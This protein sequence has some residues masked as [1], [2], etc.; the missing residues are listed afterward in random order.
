[1]STIKQLLKAEKSKGI[2]IHFELRLDK[3][4]RAGR[5]PI[6][7]VYRIEGVRKVYRTSLIILPQ[8]WD[9]K[10]QQAVYIDR[11]TAKKFYPAID[12]DYFLTE[13][14]VTDFNNQLIET[15][16]EIKTA[17]NKFINNGVAYDA[18]M[19][20]EQIKKTKAPNTK[21]AEPTNF[22]F[23]FIDQYIIDHKATREAT[24]LAVYRAMKNYLQAY[25]QHTGNRITFAKIDYSFLQSFQ[26]FLLTCTRVVGGKVV[27]R[28]NNTT[29]AKQL[30]TVKTFIS[31]AKKQGIV[32][33]DSY[34]NFQI[35]RDELEVIALTN[36]EFEA[37]YYF[38]LTNNKRLEQVRDIFCFSCST[39][40]RISDLKQLKREHIKQDEII[41][42]IMKGGR[43]LTVPLN[44]FSRAILAKYETA[45][46]PL[47]MISGQRINDYVKE[48]CELVGINEQV[49]IVRFRGIV[50]EAITYP[51]YELICAHT[52]RK[53]FVCLSLEKGMSAEQVMACTGHSTYASFKRYVNVTNKLKIVSMNKAWGEPMAQNSMRAV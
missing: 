51:K 31:Y 53:T 10:S 3:A 37:L 8:C 30:S 6:R 14:E 22:L 1:M 13:V 48:L 20:I 27:P 50:R 26:N 15:I 11:K 44:P 35:K 33:S 39:G 25:Q 7:V 34:K 52:G 2:T 36:N 32:V 28:L 40:F 9:G 29:I 18:D 16:G 17:A 42:T 21:K 5:A 41:L 45:H 49:E 23:D 38:D 43:N 19:M 47:P 46:R 12:Y 4:D 24:S